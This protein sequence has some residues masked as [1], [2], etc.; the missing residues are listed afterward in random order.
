M[1]DALEIAQVRNTGSEFMT[2]DKEVITPDEQQKWFLK[3][4]QIA[5]RIGDTYA[6]IGR[7]GAIPVAY[8]LAN[9][10]DDAYYLTGVIAP[11]AQGNGYGRQL[12]THLRDFVLDELG[13]DRVMLDVLSTNERA[14]QLYASLGFEALNHGQLVVME[15]RR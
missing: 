4:Y 7:L 6:F 5:E 12:F 2:H 3:Y 9:R 14:R 1:R 8:G 10:K 13:Q 15:C 11:E